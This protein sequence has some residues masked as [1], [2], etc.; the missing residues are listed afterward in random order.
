MV[1]HLHAWKVAFVSSPDSGDPPLGNRMFN[2]QRCW[3]LGRTLF[4]SVLGD[5]ELDGTGMHVGSKHSPSTFKA[6]TRSVHVPFSTAFCV[7]GTRS[8]VRLP[9]ILY[10]CFSFF[11]P[12][13]RNAFVLDVQRCDTPLLSTRSFRIFAT[14]VSFC[15]LPSHRIFAG[16]A[17]STSSSHRRFGFVGWNSR[18]VRTVESHVDAPGVAKGWR[19][20]RRKRGK[21]NV[22]VP[23]SLAACETEK[24]RSVARGT[25]ADGHGSGTDGNRAGRI[26]A[27]ARNEI[28]MRKRKPGEAADP[29]PS[30]APCPRASARFPTCFVRGSRWKIWQK[31]KKAPALQVTSNAAMGVERRGNNPSSCLEDD[32]S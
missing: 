24:K 29:R 26:G 2:C 21:T 12:R 15:F 32:T 10:L 30:T 18:R 1:P 8:D 17:T 9:R 23:A 5:G 6:R 20:R 14:S 16:G 28:K 7:V 11:L 22:R 31:W 27:G 3:D 19:R 4:V 25:G 13:I